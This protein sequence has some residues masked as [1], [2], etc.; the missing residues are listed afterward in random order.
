M[1]WIRFIKSARRGSAMLE[2][3]VGAGVLVSVFTGT[4]QFGYTFYQYNKLSNAVNAGARYASLRA[5]N[6]PNAT[7]ASNFNT[8]VKNMVVYGNPAGTGSPVVPGLAP[9]NVV[10]TPTFTLAVPSHMTVEIQGFTLNSVV[11][12][13]RLNHKPKVTYPYLGLYMPF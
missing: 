4:F 9:G 5:Y 7:P 1:N 13:T 6:S 3:A 2:F 8:A 12:S 10:L 11:S